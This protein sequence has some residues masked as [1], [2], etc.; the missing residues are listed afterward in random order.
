[1]T[2]RITAFINDY[3]G[4]TKA[5]MTQSFKYTSKSSIIMVIMGLSLA[6]VPFVRADALRYLINTIE[7]NNGAYKALPIFL[8]IL[9]LAATVV[10]PEIL[11]ELRLYVNKI[12]KFNL[13]EKLEVLILQKRIDI[14]IAKY[15]NPDFQNLMQRA[16][17]KGH[18]PLVS[19]SEQQFTML[20]LMVSFIVGSVLAIGI[21]PLGFVILLASSIPSLIVQ[22]KYGADV[23][24]IRHEDSPEQRRFLD[25]KRYFVDNHGIIETKLFQITP[26][27]INW[28]ER[29]LN[30]FHKKHKKLHKQ[31]VFFTLFSEL[32]FL[33]G[34]ITCIYLILL[35]HS[36]K[37]LIV[38]DLIFSIG[39]L[40]GTKFAINN[41]FNNLIRQYE[42]H[43]SVR[44]IIE[45]LDTESG[46]KTISNSSFKLTDAPEIVFENVRF[47]Y[48]SSAGWVLEDISFSISRHE[49]IALTGANGS[50]KSTIIKLL[51]KIYK[52]C[53][54]RILINGIDLGTIDQDQW[55]TYLGI[56]N[57]EYQDY[58]FIAQEAIAIG[59][60]H[61]E[62]D[63][64][65]VQES[66]QL[67]SADTFI[68]KWSGRYQTQLGAVFGGKELSKGQ[69][70][71]MALAK[72][73]YRDSFLTIL[74]EPTASIDM[75]SVQII[76]NNLSSIRKNKTLILVSHD[77]TL[78]DKCDKTL[79]L[80]NGKLTVSVHNL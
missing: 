60:I 16:F 49:M 50:G 73:L 48:P 29:I 3:W 52:P 68:E 24:N 58:R 77:P 20:N 2:Q 33:A 28:V 43:L 40:N 71:K 18:A 42:E 44:D 36:G 6:T 61:Q 69:K 78:L 17:H 23:W 41:L 26:K 1:M 25:L 54:G 12:W 34:Y 47:K 19:F 76:A 67:S 31:K 46:F 62:P 65:K 21:H 15:E 80:K 14:D 10:I 30:N 35:S 13:T 39:V 55:W 7:I 59:N 74:D 53:N 66:A 51:C 38:G 56:M 11:S 70:Q 75:Q 22:F 57:Q 5:C 9:F 72:V 45:F 8:G 32:I 63:I 64:R 27:F 4:S 79:H 37:E